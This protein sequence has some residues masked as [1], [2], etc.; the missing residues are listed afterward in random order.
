M[1]HMRAVARSGRPA[2][3]APRWRMLLMHG[4]CRLA[5]AGGGTALRR[6]GRCGRDPGLPAVRCRAP[7]LCGECACWWQQLQLHC[8]RGRHA[9]V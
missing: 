7:A 5:R 8:A 6:I 3:A 4:L 1:A 2:A 9:D